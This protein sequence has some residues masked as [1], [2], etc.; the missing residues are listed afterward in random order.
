MPN[1]EFAAIDFDRLLVPEQRTVQRGPR[2][3]AVSSGGRSTGKTTI[4]W[5]L[6]QT[7]SHLG[8]RTI[9]IDTD[10]TAAGIYH[11]AKNMAAD[12]MIQQFLQQREDVN[13]LTQS[14]PWKNLYLITGSATV[15]SHARMTFAAKQKLLL[16]LRQLKSD[17]IVL[18]AGEGSSYLHLDFFL[19]ADLAIVVTGY[20]GAQLLEA[21]QFI[22]TGFYRRLQ[23]HGRRWQDLFGYVTSLG[24][25]N[26]QGSIR[27]LPDFLRTHDIPHA[28]V[29]KIIS[30]QLRC[31]HPILLFNQVE[32]DQDRSKGPLLFKVLQE[33]MGISAAN[34]GEIRRDERIGKSLSQGKPPLMLGGPAG[35]DIGELVRKHLLS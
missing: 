18:D 3:I 7:L 4:A 32:D 34:W 22:R 11:R 10:L 27:S 33:V 29:C 17:W 23:P 2:V 14:T 9:L 21:Y 13:I 35:M 19:A 31:Y 1:A 30:D 24:E 16:Q 8:R 12:K 6:A 26:R 25:L 15:S 28:H 20:S 5:L